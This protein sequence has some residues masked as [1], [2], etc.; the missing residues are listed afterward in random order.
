MVALHSTAAYSACVCLLAKRIRFAPVG[1]FVHIVLCKICARREVS[2]V[3]DGSGT[4]YNGSRS[5][6]F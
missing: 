1:V 3:E 2:E 4:G 6:M 5:I